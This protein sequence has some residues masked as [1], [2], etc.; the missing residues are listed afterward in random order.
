MSKKMKTV[1]INRATWLTGRTLGKWIKKGDYRQF[2]TG[3]STFRDSDSGHMC[4]LGFVGAQCGL[5]RASL[6]VNIPSDLTDY[7]RAKYPK[8][9]LPKRKGSENRLALDL[10]SANDSD[11][12]T[13][14][15]REK[16]VRTGLRKAGIRVKF[17]GKYR[18]LY[19]SAIL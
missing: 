18:K 8:T 7:A 17:V 14:R 9:L 15:E 1:R 6:S 4:C 12:L 2:I 3:N 5:D 13:N 10:M 19:D 16:A 11:A